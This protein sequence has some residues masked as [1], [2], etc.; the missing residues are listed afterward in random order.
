MRPWHVWRTHP[1]PPTQMTFDEVSIVRGKRAGVRKRVVT[2]RPVEL[3]LPLPYIREEGRLWSTPGSVDMPS[4]DTP[5]T[6]N[7]DLEAWDYTRGE[8]MRWF[9]KMIGPISA[10]GFIHADGMRM[11]SATFLGAM[12]G[13]D[14]EQIFVRRKYAPMGSGRAQRYDFLLTPPMVMFCDLSSS[15]SYEDIGPLTFWIQ[16]EVFEATGEIMQGSPIGQKEKSS[17]KRQRWRPGRFS[18]SRRELA[19]DTSGA[20]QSSAE[21][22]AASVV[23]IALD[24]YLE[25]G[26]PDPR[27]V[28]PVRADEAVDHDPF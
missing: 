9:V 11:R 4:W 13:I 10:D 3:E 1:H 5:R 17:T 16:P 21:R 12:L 25:L 23:I 15:F 24:A 26:R 27:F 7:D 14:L 22:R 6:A 19:G 18:I 28:D 2:P 20:P 8:F